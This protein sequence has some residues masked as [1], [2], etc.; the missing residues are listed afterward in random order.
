MFLTSFG[1]IHAE[2]GVS[3]SFILSGTG[4]GSNGT[5]YVLTSSNLLTPLVQWTYI[6]TNQFDSQGDFIFT[7]TAQTNAPQLFYLLQLP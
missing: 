4:G 1:N 2:S 6:A 3:G 7:N 5:Y